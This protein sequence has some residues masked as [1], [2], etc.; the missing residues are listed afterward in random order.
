MKYSVL[1]PASFNLIT[2]PHQGHSCSVYF[3]VLLL[4]LL[5][6][7]LTRCFIILTQIPKYGGQTWYNM[8]QRGSENSPNIWILESEQPSLKSLKIAI[9]NRPCLNSVLHNSGLKNICFADGVTM[10]STSMS[11]T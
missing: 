7:I 6:P 3:E 2:G 8:F 1:F 4:L 10:H 5:L 11:A 9:Q